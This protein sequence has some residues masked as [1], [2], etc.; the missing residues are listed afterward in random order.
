MA[1]NERTPS[2][3]EQYAANTERNTRQSRN[4]LGWMLFLGLV[5]IVGSL[6][7]GVIV[8]SHVQSNP[9]TVSSCMSQGGVD[10]SC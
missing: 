7:T 4:I 6:V 9:V 2:I 8:A 5:M 10:A 3:M 1:D